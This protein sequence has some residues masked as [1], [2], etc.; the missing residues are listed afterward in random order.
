[1]LDDSY[2][3][4]FQIYII[5]STSSWV[6]FRPAAP[7]IN[8]VTGNLNKTFV[9]SIKLARLRS[10]LIDVIPGRQSLPRLHEQPLLQR[11]SVEGRIYSETKREN[12][13][14]SVVRDHQYP[15]ECNQ[16]RTRISPSF[17]R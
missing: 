2:V 5:T 13:N 7:A 6:L 12:N 3:R 8:E 16:M 15:T 10:A 11:I 9:K 17:P 14:E 4:I 1:M